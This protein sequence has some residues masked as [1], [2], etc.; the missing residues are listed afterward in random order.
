M[1]SDWSA[2]AD[3]SP[4]LIGEH[5]RGAKMGPLAGICKAQ[6]YA[7]RTPSLSILAG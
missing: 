6:F 5:P 3:S 2:C 7:A 4:F 1:V